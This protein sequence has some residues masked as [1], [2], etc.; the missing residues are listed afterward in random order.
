MY[1]V[2]IT[3]FA[4]FLSS[5][6][7]LF[8][9]II[10]EVFRK[11]SVFCTICHIYLTLFGKD[12]SPNMLPSQILLL[13]TRLTSV[14]SWTVVVVTLPVVDTMMH[15]PDPCLKYFLL[16]CGVFTVVS[17][18]QGGLAKEKQLTQSFVPS[19]RRFPSK[20]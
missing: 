17:L 11:K 7:P 16:H 14:T 9:I 18:L 5:E 19:L 20:D 10:S 4:S 3:L 2:I 1:S 6:L 15:Y 8:T 13:H 12:S